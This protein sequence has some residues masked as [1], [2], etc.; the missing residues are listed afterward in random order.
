MFLNFFGVKARS[1]SNRDSSTKPAHDRSSLKRGGFASRP[2][3]P[4][5]HEAF[6]LADSPI[7]TMRGGW[8]S[9]MKEKK[10]EEK[11]TKKKN[12]GLL[13]KPFGYPLC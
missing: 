9:T 10:K 13:T 4:K 3:M 7:L 1:Q 6:W 12:S 5:I 8:T 2:F 11:K